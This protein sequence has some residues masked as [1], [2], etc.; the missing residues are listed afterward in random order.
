[1]AS[2]DATRTLL[3][4]HSP[5]RRGYSDAADTLREGLQ[6]R[7]GSWHRLDPSHGGGQRPQ[8]DQCYPPARRDAAVA[9]VRLAFKLR[10]KRNV[11][12]MLMGRNYAQP[13]RNPE[14]VERQARLPANID[15]I[16][17]NENR[18]AGSGLA[19]KIRALILKDWGAL[20]RSGRIP[21]LIHVEEPPP[22]RYY[23]KM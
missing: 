23:F 22:S 18:R 15:H 16:D 4:A 3:G 14:T 13:G 17:P 19:A 12:I 8:C 21:S 7:C 9:P 20:T 11:K 6:Q 1:V 10:L 2:R 5:W